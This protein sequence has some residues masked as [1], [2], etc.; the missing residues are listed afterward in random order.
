MGIGICIRC[1]Y[2]IR[3]PGN[4]RSNCKGVV[5]EH[6]LT[7]SILLNAPLCNRMVMMNSRDEAILPGPLRFAFSKWFLCF[8]LIRYWKFYRACLVP[9]F[10][11]VPIAFYM[12]SSSH[13]CYFHSLTRING[14]KGS[15]WS[16]DR[17][18][19]AN[20]ASAKT[21]LSIDGSQG[22]KEIAVFIMGIAKGC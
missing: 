8:V 21:L 7:V 17:L 12:T 13:V 22:L 3:T 19:M 5:F 1:P 6:S 10:C 14:L 16:L 9:C 15:C 4:C 2:S 18:V 11:N 20:F